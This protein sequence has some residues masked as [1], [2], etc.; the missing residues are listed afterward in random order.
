[1]KKNLHTNL[2]P[3]F[4]ILALLKHSW[5]SLLFILPVY[6]GG[7]QLSF[8]SASLIS[9]SG[10]N[11]GSKWKFLNVKTGVDATVELVAKS[12]NN[13]NISTIDQNSSGYN[14]ALQPNISIS[15]GSGT[16]Y[17]AEFNIRFFKSGTSTPDTLSN[18]DIGCVDM[19]GSSSFAESHYY[20]N[21][22]NYIID[23][24][25]NVVASNPSTV[26]VSVKFVGINTSLLNV[27]TINKNAMANINYINI[28]QISFRL[29]MTRNTSGTFNTA[30]RLHSLYFKK[31]VY[32][33]PIITLP[34][35]FTKF[36]AKLKNNKV[37]L[38]WTTVNSFDLA[39]L[40]VQKSIDCKSFYTIAILKARNI[41]QTEKYSY[42]DD[43][44][45]ELAQKAFYRIKAIDSDRTEHY[46]KTISVTPVQVV[47][48]FKTHYN[49]ENGTLELL[50]PVSYY[51]SIM[52]V[53]FYNNSGQLLVNREV[54]YAGENEIFNISFYPS[55]K[56]YL[57]INTTKSNKFVSFV[58]F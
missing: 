38:I 23:S 25:S 27:D 10:N 41:A 15:S 17:W 57:K 30:I 39:A 35:N 2:I 53:G 16:E 20:F 49:V 34:L 54:K 32:S 8:V 36:N 7:Q 26:P 13:V 37:E 3:E 45:D 11:I 40:E 58:K 24:S 46:S 31:F 22:N 5:F 42:I 29:G 21:Y 1:M 44:T 47:A 50:T 19:D 9:G 14:V 18:V 51:N 43:S 33:R 56:Y 4:S 48:D 12:N 52:T 55:G 6:L 28:S